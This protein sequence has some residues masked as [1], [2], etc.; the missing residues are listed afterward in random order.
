MAGLPHTKL[1]TGIMRTPA[2]RECKFY[3]EDFHRGRSRQECRLI[4]AQSGSGRWHPRDC[5]RCPV[6][7]ILQANASPHL[8]LEAEIK[9]GIL[10]IGR[11]VSVRAWCAKH[12]TEIEDPYVGCLK[13]AAERPG[14]GLFFSHEADE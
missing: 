8:Q 5:E 9:P 3:Y 14:L 4:K 2:G 7:D 11:H 1:E 10:G 13:C 6:P 12:G